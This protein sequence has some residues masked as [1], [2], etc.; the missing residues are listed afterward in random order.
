MPYLSQ[1]YN[2]VF[3]TRTVLKGIMNEGLGVIEHA[4]FEFFCRCKS[5]VVVL[6]LAVPR[7]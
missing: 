6:C 5:S 7:K 4:N 2:T 3:Q 1:S